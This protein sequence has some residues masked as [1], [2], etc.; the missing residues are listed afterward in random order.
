MPLVSNGY[1]L[2]NLSVIASYPGDSAKVLNV[3]FADNKISFETEKNNLKDALVDKGF[4]ITSDDIVE[5]GLDTLLQPGSI[6]VSIKKAVP[7]FIVDGQK[8]LVGKSAHL[9]AQD[10]LSDLSVSVYP[11]DEV[12]VADPTDEISPALKIY[13]KRANV[14]NLQIDGQIKEVH[15]NLPT[16]LDLLNLE[17]IVLGPTDRVEPSLDTKITDGL[18]VNIIRVLE[19]QNIEIVDIPFAQEV[20]K[21]ENLMEGQ[22]KIEKQ[23]EVGKKEISFKSVIENGIVVR[24]DILSEKILKEPVS[25]IVIKGTKP[26]VSYASGSYADLINGAAQKYGV[27]GAKM[28][29]MMI[30]ESGG[31]S[32]SVGGG[33]RFHGLFQYMTSTWA[34]ASAGAGYQGASIYNPEA[35][36]YTTAWKISR[37]GYG[38]WPIC[39]RR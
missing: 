28:Q 29:R 31:N 36:I 10:I 11:D 12:T 33:G 15:T 16:V 20:K 23:G 14:V 9:S 38:A 18:S 37:Q 35:Q 7:V 27:D 34:G 1:I 22:T 26:K 8:V 2:P 5:P 4:S 21:D 13:I 39:G 24:K 3:S 25:Q 30:C 19:N 32:N 17:K 6:D